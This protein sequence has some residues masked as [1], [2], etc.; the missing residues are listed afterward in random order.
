MFKG[1]NPFTILYDTIIFYLTSYSSRVLN[2]QWVN[3]HICMNLNKACVM[4]G[5]LKL[6]HKFIKSDHRTGTNHSLKR[7]KDFK[8]CLEQLA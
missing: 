5:S 3:K 7:I 2:L 8:T 4:I 6:M 1:D